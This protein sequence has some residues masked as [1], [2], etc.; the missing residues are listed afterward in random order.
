MPRRAHH[1]FLGDSPHLFR[2]LKR[3][4]FLGG[5]K[6]P[7]WRG[8]LSP[9][10]VG[11]RPPEQEQFR[12]QTIGVDRPKRTVNAKGPGQH[13]N[14]RSSQIPRTGKRTKDPLV[15]ASTGGPNP[16]HR[17]PDGTRNTPWRQLRLW[18]AVRAVNATWTQSASTRTARNRAG[19][20]RTAETAPKLHAGNGSGKTPRRLPLTKQRSDEYDEM[21]A[22]PDVT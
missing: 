4:G 16:S 12:G 18:F 5:G 2:V 8:D 1:Q 13:M 17:F 9:T 15:R 7:D 3:D 10:S 11:S 14:L 19:E 22:W 20:S 6:P 21:L